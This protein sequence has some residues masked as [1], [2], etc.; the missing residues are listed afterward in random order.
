MP[1]QYEMA[2]TVK[3]ELETI[4]RKAGLEAISYTTWDDTFGRRLRVRDPVRAP[5]SKRSFRIEKQ[6]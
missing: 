3:S 4:Q 1:D 5:R 6:T 2:R